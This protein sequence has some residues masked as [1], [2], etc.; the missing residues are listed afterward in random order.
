MQGKKT[1]VSLLVLLFGSFISSGKYVEETNIKKVWRNEVE[2]TDDSRLMEDK[3]EE[4]E[5]EYDRDEREEEEEYNR[6]KYREEDEQEERDAGEEVVH[7]PEQSSEERSQEEADDEDDDEDNP[8]EFD[9]E[10]EEVDN[11]QDDRMMDQDEGGMSL[12]GRTE[13]DV[14]NETGFEGFKRKV[15]E[16]NKANEE[17]QTEI[18]KLK[19]EFDKALS[20]DSNNDEGRSAPIFYHGTF[21]SDSQKNVQI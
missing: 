7:I 10:E 8:R 15:E 11:L 18:N 17:M 12:A 9:D 3:G 6:D 20:S 4:E 5:E 1:F 13:K 14:P 2:E 21:I 19:V 16:I